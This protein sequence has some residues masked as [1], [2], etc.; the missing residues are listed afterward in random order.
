MRACCRRPIG[1]ARNSCKRF[2]G[3]R[4][5]LDFGGHVPGFGDHQA[6]LVR[7]SSSTPTLAI[8]RTRESCSSGKPPTWGPPSDAP[9]VHRGD[10]SDSWC[11]KR[12]AAR[13]TRS[14][15]SSR[16][17]MKRARSASIFL[18]AHLLA[19]TE[20]AEQH[21]GHA[22]DDIPGKDRIRAVEGSGSRGEGDTT[23]MPTTM[24]MTPTATTTIH[25]GLP[26]RWNFSAVPAGRL[27][28]GLISVAVYAA[29]LRSRET[30]FHFGCSSFPPALPATCRGAPWRRL[31]VSAGPGA[32]SRST[33]HGAGFWW[34]VETTPA[35][36]LSRGTPNLVPESETPP[37]RL[38]AGGVSCRCRS[39]T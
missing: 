11:P 7:G 22:E 27:L 32:S 9:G 26:W 19:T 17:S 3:G 18:M 37:Q 36:F 23:T 4:F 15:R 21:A 24:P 31:L 20:S 35:G 38:L 14:R 30:Q 39:M 10:T 12:L 1:S 25:H 29:G 28:P 8:D 16:T 33:D 34:C 6:A 2:S 5:H 13:P